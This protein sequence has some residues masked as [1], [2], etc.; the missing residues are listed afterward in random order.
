M[1]AKPPLLSINR[2]FSAPVI[3]DG[4]AR[5]RRARAAGADRQR[6]LR[7]LRGDA[8]VDDAR[9]DRAAQRAAIADAAPVI[10][11][12]GA[13]LSS[14]ALDPAFKAEAILLPGEALIADRMDV[15]DPDAIHEAR[16]ALAARRSARRSRDELLAA[17][18]PRAS[19][20]ERPVARGQG[21]P[22]AAHRRARPD[23]RGRSRRRRSAGQGAVR[24]RRQHDRPPGRAR[25]SWCRSTGPSA[26]PRWPPFTTGSSDDPLVIDKWFAMQAAAQRARYDRRRSRALADHPDFTMANP[27]RLRALAGTFGANQWAFNRRDGRGYTLARRHDHRRRQAEP[28]GRGA[29]GPAVRPLAQVR[30]EA[31]GA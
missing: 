7:P 31:V 26:R 19:Q 1:S 3:V 20:R 24:R 18:M 17:F 29:A 27:N 5:A 13:T 16:E 10:D 11:A 12:V 28:A 4:R 21:R 22:P 6:S 8:G 9:A 15:I 14:N 23:R 25:R 30:A 2:D